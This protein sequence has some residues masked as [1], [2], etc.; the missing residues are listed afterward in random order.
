MGLILA[1]GHPI[2]APEE[3]E[4]MI[5]IRKQSIA[6]AVVAVA[7]AVPVSGALGCPIP[8]AKQDPP[9]AKTRQTSQQHA[10]RQAWSSRSHAPRF[11]VD[12]I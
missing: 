10:S 1:S 11:G 9:A 3:A 12:F 4:E 8:K 7:F 2:I 6:A 5:S